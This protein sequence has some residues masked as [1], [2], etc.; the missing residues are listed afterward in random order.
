ML[1]DRIAE[2]LVRSGETSLKLAS[3]AMVSF[4]QASR[5]PVTFSDTRSYERYWGTLILRLA[6]ADHKNMAAPLLRVVA[7]Q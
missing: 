4:T 7:T 3:A 6:T 5:N 2:W 1:D